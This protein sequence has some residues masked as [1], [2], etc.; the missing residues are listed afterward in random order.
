[1]PAT[2]APPTRSTPSTVSAVSVSLGIPETATDTRQ[3]SQTKTAR[4]P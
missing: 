4:H 1:M 3:G 2:S